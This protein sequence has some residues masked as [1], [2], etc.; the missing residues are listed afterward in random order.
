MAALQT[1]AEP[2][3]VMAYLV[4]WTLRDDEGTRVVIAGVSAETLANAIDALDEDRFDEIYT[5]MAAHVAAMKAERDSEKNGQGDGRSKPVI[6]PSLAGV[7]G[8]LIGSV[9]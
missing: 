2:A 3:V 5:V 9:S 1:L 8:Q 6:S 7:T 4:D